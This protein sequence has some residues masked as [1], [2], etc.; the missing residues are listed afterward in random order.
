MSWDVLLFRL[1]DGVTSVHEIP[2]DQ[3]PD[4]LGRR[5]DVLAALTQAVPEADLSDPTWGELSGPTWSIELNIGP[6]RPGGLDYAPHPRLRRRRDE[7]VFR[8]AESL[9]CEV[10]DC[11]EGDLITP[12]QS[13]GWHSVVAWSGW[14][15]ATRSSSH[16]ITQGIF[17]RG[18]GAAPRRGGS[19]P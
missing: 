11:A 13:S 19:L 18:T 1:P 5:H 4:P 6:R 16:M 15:P 2:A 10:L 7:P 9:R 12:G 14:P 17:G 8:L 3:T